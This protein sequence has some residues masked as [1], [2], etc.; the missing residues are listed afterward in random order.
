MLTRVCFKGD[1]DPSQDVAM[2]TV[3]FLVDGKLV[4]L[5]PSTTEGGELKYDMRVLLQNVEFYILMRD[6]PA[7]HKLPSASSTSAIDSLNIPPQTLN[8]SLWV[9]DGQD[10]QVSCWK[11]TITFQNHRRIAG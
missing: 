2:A 8:D 9:F 7:V 10:V 4:L 1:G 3:L 6:I 5:Q 11:P